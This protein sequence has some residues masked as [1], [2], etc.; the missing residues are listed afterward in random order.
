MEVKNV[1]K[2]FFWG[3]NSTFNLTPLLKYLEIYLPLQFN[4]ILKMYGKTLYLQN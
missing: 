4:K 3:K 2:F 1:H